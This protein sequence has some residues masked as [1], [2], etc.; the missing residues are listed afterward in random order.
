[1]A[2]ISSPTFWANISIL[3]APWHCGQIKCV[4]MS[5][6]VG[7]DI[8]SS[9]DPLRIFLILFIYYTFICRPIKR[10]SLL[11]NTFLSQETT[12]PTRKHKPNVNH[13]P[14]EREFASCDACPLT[15]R[16]LFISV[17]FMLLFSVSV[18]LTNHKHYKWE[19]P[20]QKKG[21]KKIYINYYY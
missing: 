20:T 2:M 9:P 11:E 12:Q 4:Y 17:H 14:W 18:C 8:I 10:R 3:R 6:E 13:I 21:A 1:M 15:F 19:K 7:R 5:V 16:L